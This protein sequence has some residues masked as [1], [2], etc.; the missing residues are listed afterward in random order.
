MK[1]ETSSQPDQMV[2]DLGARDVR[3]SSGTA[4]ATDVLAIVVE[5]ATAYQTELADRATRQT[6]VLVEI[7]SRDRPRTA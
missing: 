4:T 7:L 6:R 3:Q 5:E 2:I 1:V